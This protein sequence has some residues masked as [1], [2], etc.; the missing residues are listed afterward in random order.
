MYKLGLTQFNIPPWTTSLH[1]MAAPHNAITQAAHSICTPATP[2]L[3]LR[4]PQR[5]QTNR[6]NTRHASP[7]PQKYPPFSGS[8]RTQGI[9]ATTH[10]KA[11]PSGRRVAAA[12]RVLPE[13][14]NLRLLADVPTE[15]PGAE[16]RD[17][18]RDVLGR[19]AEPDCGLLVSLLS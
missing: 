2:L 16:L 10:R 7:P 5:R 3:L 9:H 4:R 15:R 18:F 11:L 13:V 8:T 1:P 6:T 12:P 19:V 14:E 17:L